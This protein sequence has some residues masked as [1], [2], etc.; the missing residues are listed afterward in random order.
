MSEVTRGSGGGGRW[1][2]QAGIVRDADSP[3]SPQRDGALSMPLTSLVSRRS[4]MMHGLPFC[5]KSRQTVT[6]AMTKRP[7]CAFHPVLS[8][9]IATVNC[10]TL[11]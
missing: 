9:L 11:A 7:D 4:S 5:L 3:W 10:F 1:P 6:A 2:L 8:Y